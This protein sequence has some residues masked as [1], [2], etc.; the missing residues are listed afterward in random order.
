MSKLTEEIEEW[1]LG[2]D[3]AWEGN[4]TI[5]ALLVLLVKANAALKQSISRNG[6]VNIADK[7]ADDSGQINS[8]SFAIALKQHFEDKSNE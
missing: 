5:E 2:E 7:L 8:D 1:T 6:A 3:W 4:D